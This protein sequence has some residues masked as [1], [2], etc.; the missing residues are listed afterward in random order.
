MLFV[1]VMHT[2]GEKNDGV[3]ALKRGLPVGFGPIVSITT[4][5]SMPSGVRT[6]PRTDYPSRASA[7]TT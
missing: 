3:D 6:T 2:C 4:S 1:L 5:S 7:G